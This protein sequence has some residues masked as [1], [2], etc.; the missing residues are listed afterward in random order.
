MTSRFSSLPL[1]AA[2]ALLLAACGGSGEPI[3]I[4]IAGPTSQ[5]NGRSMK[6]A[7]E[8]AA[9]EINRAGGIGGRPVELKILDDEAKPEK[10]IAVATELRDD[11]RVVAVIGHVNSPATLAAATIY[12]D[13]EGGDPVPQ[14]SPAS[15]SPQV[16]QAGPWTFRVCPSDLLHGPVVAN[17][18]YGE[19]GSRRAAVL[20]TNDTYGRGVSTTF[21]EAFRKAGGTVVAL[22]PYLKASVEAPGGVDAYLA[23]ALRNRADALMVAGQADAG[24]KIVQAARRL[25]FT[26]PVVGADGMT[27]VKDAG[28]DAEGIFVSSAFLPDRSSPAAQA[29]VKAYVQKYNELPDHRGA[30]T[31]DA[32]KLLARA[33]A[34]A[35]ADRGKI[36]AYLEQVGRKQPKFEGVSGT[37]EFD[38]HGDVPGKEVAVGV[39]RSGKLVSAK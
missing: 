33:I 14:I 30:M 27:G 16:T 5:A 22:D 34:D 20:Y 13:E 24:V 35:G 6:L 12:N 9:D 11:A 4:G 23:R 15:S 28:A 17:W 37:I 39:V 29:F 8:M 26:G 7:A 2:L 32:L 25:G 1:S 10:A 21:S 3:R 31:Y 36:R 38:E 19:L 18:T